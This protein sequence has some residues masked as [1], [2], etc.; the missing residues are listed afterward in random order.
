MEAKEERII[1]EAEKLFLRVGPSQMT[2]DA[3][4]HNCGISKRTLYETFPDKRSLIE[5]C[6]S[7]MHARQNEQFRVIFEQSANCFEAM[8][9]VYN[10]LREYLRAN[11]VE[12]KNDVTRL[13]PDMM[14]RH[15]EEEIKIIDGLSTV[16]NTAQDEG[17]V[18]AHINTK[19]AS[20]LF[21]STMQ[22]IH[23][24]DRVV[25][26]GF[27]RVEVFDGAFINFMRGVASP[28]GLEQIESYL[29]KNDKT[30]LR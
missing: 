24:N 5:C 22:N 2:M 14:E 11:M 19:I 6:L 25:E 7:R 27:D 3:V 29:S 17:L 23:H 10:T 28:R 16:L 30:N 1:K 18:V 8:F 15:R 4:A 12:I 21:L 9:K 13:Y 26:L 20:F